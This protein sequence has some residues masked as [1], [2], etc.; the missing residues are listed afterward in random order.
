MFLRLFAIPTLLLVLFVS[1]FAQESQEVWVA[2]H[3]GPGKGKASAGG[4]AVDRGP[5]GSARAVYVTG[6]SAGAGGDSDYAT[7]KYSPEG[8]ELWV[9]RYNGIRSE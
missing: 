3:N 5:D 2:R 9:A 6:F 1:A 8:K 4:L 7:V